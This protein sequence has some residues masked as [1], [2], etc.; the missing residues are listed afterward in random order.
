MFATWRCFK[1]KIKK[2]NLAERFN[3]SYSFIFR[4]DRNWIKKSAR[5]SEKLVSL[6]L[7]DQLVAMHLPNM[8]TIIK[9]LGICA[10][11]ANSPPFGRRLRLFK[12]EYTNNLP[13]KLHNNINNLPIWVTFKP[14][15]DENIWHF[16]TTSNGKKVVLQALFFQLLSV[17]A[18]FH[19]GGNGNESIYYWIIPHFNTRPHAKWGLQHPQVWC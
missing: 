8:V 17:T 3:L 1:W 9:M 6:G 16:H 2:T 4:N 7:P 12:I 14:M 5:I 19:T 11:D 10:L 18:Q 13:F 15:N